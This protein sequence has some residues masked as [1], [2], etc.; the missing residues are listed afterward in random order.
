MDSME[1]L[2]Q[3]ADNRKL[4]LITTGMPTELRRDYIQDFYVLVAP[5][6]QNRPFD[7]RSNKAATLVETAESPR[8]DLQKTAYE[9][10]DKNGDWI[11]KVVEN[12]YPAL[13]S[14]NP[15]AYGKQELVIDT[16][17]RNVSFGE[18]PLEQ[19]E[20]ILLTYQQ[21]AGELVKLPHI[22][23]VAIFRNDGAGA[24]ASLAHAHSQIAALPIVPPKFIREADAI[25]K[26]VAQH[27]K[28]PFDMIIELE[29]KDTRRIIQDTS[30]WISFA[31]YA[32]AW[33]MEAWIMPK[34]PISQLSEASEEDIRELARHVLGV[35]K[36]LTELNIDYNLAI[37]QGSRASQR[38]TVKIRGRSV[39]SP[40]GGLEV[41]TDVIINA[42]PPEAAADWYRRGL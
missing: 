29:Q 28:D 17:L 15:H 5:K 24:G 40:R 6:R 39:L 42:I 33:Q 13:S 19:I 41:M 38:L 20:E 7:T 14:D 32:S 4:D 25:D 37:E 8:L 30:A 34:Q 1:T 27:N 21:R 12:K 11:T 31:P 2:S 16:A 26:Y 10:L 36:Q 3:P 35:T 9:R 22:A 18:L 23:Y